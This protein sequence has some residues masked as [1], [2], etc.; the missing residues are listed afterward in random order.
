MQPCIKSALI[1][2]EQKA[3]EVQEKLQKIEQLEPSQFLNM[4]RDI[5]IKLVNKLEDIEDVNTARGALRS[6]IGEIKLIPENGTLT[7]EI[8]N[9]GLAGVLQITV[10]AGAGFEPTTFGL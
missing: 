3:V 7:A 6:L 10:V 9:A 8:E 1:D 5:Y 2:A 4:V